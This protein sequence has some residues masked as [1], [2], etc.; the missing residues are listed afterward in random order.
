MMQLYDNN[1]IELIS[2]AVLAAHPNLNRILLEGQDGD[3]DAYLE[4][5]RNTPWKSLVPQDVPLSL[6]PRILVKAN[7]WR[8]QTSHSHLDALFFLMREKND[9]LLQ[10]VRK[11]KI[12]KRKRFQIS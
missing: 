12:R 3:D 2:A 11:R 7:T 6:W 4:V 1:D 5:K 10:N 8:S 9:V